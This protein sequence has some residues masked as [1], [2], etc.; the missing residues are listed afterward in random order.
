MMIDDGLMVMTD[1]DGYGDGLD[2]KIL[3]IEM[4]WALALVNPLFKQWRP[5][6]QTVLRFS[7]CFYLG[8]VLFT[9]DL[10][11]SSQSNRL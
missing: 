7:R 1:G 8:K 11:S 6:C 3:H 5:V 4:L 9:P 10:K 2:R